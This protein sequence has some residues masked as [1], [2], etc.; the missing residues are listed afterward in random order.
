MNKRKE[1]DEKGREDERIHEKRLDYKV[2]LK[3]YC[4]L[5]TISF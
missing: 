3:S 4:K 1:D 5:L 2:T